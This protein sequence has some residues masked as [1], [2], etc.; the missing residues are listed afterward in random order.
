MNENPFNFDSKAPLPKLAA[1]PTRAPSLPRIPEPERLE[2]IQ[3]AAD[4]PEYV[5]TA[6]MENI[7]RRVDELIER[8]VTYSGSPMPH[9]DMTD[10]QIK[11]WSK[12][13]GLAAT[14]V[15]SHAF[16]DI[17]RALMRSSYDR[18]FAAGRRFERAEWAKDAREGKL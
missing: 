14:P 10:E 2:K 5:T 11:D 15:Q 3:T 18:G 7:R 8:A 16:W 13:A 17:Q 4:L 1:D 9:H 12:R 6:D